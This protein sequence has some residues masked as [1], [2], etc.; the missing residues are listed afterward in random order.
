MKADP[1]EEQLR[2]PACAIVEARV[3]CGANGF[4]KKMLGL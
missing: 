4:S 2:D 1:V 3:R